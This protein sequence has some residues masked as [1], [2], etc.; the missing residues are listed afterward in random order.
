MTPLF[1][2]MALLL[3]MTTAF[4]DCA[5]GIGEDP[6]RFTKLG[7]A[8][9]FTGTHKVIKNSV[10]VLSHYEDGYKQGIE[11]IFYANGAISTELYYVDSVQQG[12]E[13]HYYPTGEKK[14][15]IDQPSG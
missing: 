14:A 3:I 15:V 6:A 4:S 1:V 9:P 7:D 10:T 13:T 8:A 11:Q 12:D 2:K 5:A